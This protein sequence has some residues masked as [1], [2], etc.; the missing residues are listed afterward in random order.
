MF[1]FQG[2]GWTLIEGLQLTLSVGVCA[3]LVA[4]LFGLLGAA[5]KLSQ[6]RAARYV[7]EAYTAIIRGVPELILLLLVYYGVPTLIQDTAE[8]LG[9]ELIVDL[10][11]FTAGALTIGFVYGAFSTEVFRGAF[12][13]IDKG[14]IEAARAMGMSSRLVFRRILFPQALRFALPGLGN[15]WMVL[16]KATALISIIQLEEIMRKAHIASGATRQP[17]TFFLAAAALFLGITLVSMFV[18]KRLENWAS[19]GQLTQS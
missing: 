6:F 10:N 7:A 19:R 1:N 3:M 16:I 11:P 4:V 17:F 9:Y 15:V 2:Y 12:Q 8:S 14:Q 5:G 18:Q 13:A